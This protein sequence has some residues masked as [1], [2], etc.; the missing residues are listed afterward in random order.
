M[1]RA[2]VA[3]I[4]VVVAV[5]VILT[6]FALN[7]Y[8]YSS[9]REN[10]GK[11]VTVTVQGNGSTVII[12]SGR[13]ITI[14]SND[15]WAYA[16]PVINASS[17]KYYYVTF[18]L[19]VKGYYILTGSWQS[20]VFS[21]FILC[22]SKICMG[23]PAPDQTQGAVRQTISPGYYLIEIGGWLGDNVTITSSIEATSYH[24]YPVGSFYLPSGT[25]ITGPKTYSTYLNESACLIGSFTV[26][27]AFSFSVNGDNGSF[28]FGSSNTSA[29]PLLYKFNPFFPN[30]PR[31]FSPG[32]VNI[33][34]AE[35][36]FYINQTME[37]VYYV[38]SST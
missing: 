17:P 20:T 31:P 18:E 14:T 25:V 32:F 21:L 38:D 5:T 7:E 33:T 8:I 27:G 24:P 37:F 22:N 34:F 2:I 11:V 3:V 15:R 12:P 10:L 9:Q 28:S 26:E 19:H 35:G 16:G 29:K 6:A 1:K 4:A 23:P 36:T 30:S 13:T